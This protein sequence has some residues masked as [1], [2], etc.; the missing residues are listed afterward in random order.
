MKVVIEKNGTRYSFPAMVVAMSRARYYADNDPDTD[1]NS[2]YEYTMKNPS[3]IL[4]WAQN[5][6][7]PEDIDPVNRKLEVQGEPPTFEDCWS[8]DEDEGGKEWEVV[9]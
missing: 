5:N 8:A 1:Y 3:E 9:Q 6:M 2:E 4:D 7:N